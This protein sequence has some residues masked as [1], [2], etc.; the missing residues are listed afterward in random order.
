MFGIFPIFPRISPFSP[1]FWVLA[2]LG[3]M[4]T[5]SMLYRIFFLIIL[6][7]FS[8]I[9]QFCPGSTLFW[10]KSPGLNIPI[11]IF[12]WRTCFEKPKELMIIFSF[13]DLDQLPNKYSEECIFQGYLSYSKHFWQILN[14]NVKEMKK[15][16]RNYK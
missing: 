9:L 3:F 16:I 12:V 4:G 8:F 5:F 2:P 11:K 6:V 15:M 13:R 10:A 1:V 7:P 14:L